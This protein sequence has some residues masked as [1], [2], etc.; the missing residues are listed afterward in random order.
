MASESPKAVIAATVANFAIAIT[1]FIAAALGGSASMLAEGVHSLIDMA[2][3]GFM[4]LGNHLSKKPPDEQH[5]FGHGKDLY[6]WTLIVA[7]SIFGIG[8]GVT[9]VEGVER[10][11]H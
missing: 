5:P 1:K 2:N 11:L 6:F 8:G 9:I 4:L 10:L 3:G 7:T